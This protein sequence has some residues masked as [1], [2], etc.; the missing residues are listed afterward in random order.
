MKDQKAY[1]QVKLSKL[2]KG[3]WDSTI[4]STAETRKT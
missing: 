1:T 4:T 2:R 3:V